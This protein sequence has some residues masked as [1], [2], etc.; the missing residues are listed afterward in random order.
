M[1]M[2]LGGFL[3]D[4]QVRLRAVDGRGCWGL[5]EKMDDRHLKKDPIATVNLNHYSSSDTDIF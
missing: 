5:I 4:E 3:T 2:A 1:S